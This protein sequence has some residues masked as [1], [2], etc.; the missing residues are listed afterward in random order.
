MHY[1]E[2]KAAVASEGM[3]VKKFK[4]VILNESKKCKINH[5]QLMRSLA[6]NLENQLMVFNS[7]EGNAE[8]LLSAMEVLDPSTWPAK[9]PVS[10]GREDVLFYLVYSILMLMKQGEAYKSTLMVYS[11]KESALNLPPG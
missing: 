3:V 1:K 6:A 9:C 4:N 5:G 8:K 11:M 7:K 2:A 10:Y